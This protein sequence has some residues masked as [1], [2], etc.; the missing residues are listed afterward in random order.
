MARPRAIVPVST[1][2]NFLRICIYG[3]PDAGKT[4]L[5]GTSP[6]CLILANDVDEVASAARFGSKADMWHV[7]DWDEMEKAAEWVRLE[8]VN[9]YEFVWVDNGTLFQD[10][11]LEDT[12]LNA[13]QVL[14]GRQ[15]KWVPDRPQ[16]LVNQNR[17]AALIRLFKSMPIH[18]GITAHEMRV[19]YAD[20][21]EELMPAFPGTAGQYAQKICGYMNVIGHLESRWLKGGIYEANL[22]VR[23]KTGVMAKDRYH[24]L[25]ISVK[26]PNIETMIADIRK[27]LPTLGQRVAPQPVRKATGTRKVAA[28]VKKAPA[29]KKATAVKKAP[30]KAAATKKRG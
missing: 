13:K 5:A 30:A 16:Y 20:G 2:R 7:P 28:P 12:L 14:E 6:K 15:S 4:V 21:T 25:G 11:G 9:E 3:K 1:E 18:F 23:H 29:T 8:G 27:V 17:L 24:A 22:R 19:E 10:Q 26:N